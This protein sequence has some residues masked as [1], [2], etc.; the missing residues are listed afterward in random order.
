LTTTWQILHVDDEE[1]QTDLVK[2]YL[3][4]ETTV[5]GEIISVTSQNNFDEAL[6]LLNKQ[7]FDLIILDIR[8]GPID[9]DKEFTEDETGIQ[10]LLQIQQ[11]RFL[12]VIFYTGLPEAV[13]DKKSSFIKVIVK[14]GSSDLPKILAALNEYSNDGFHS[15]PLLEVNR[16]LINHLKNSSKYYLWDC[17]EKNW[18]YFRELKDHTEIVH[19]LCRHLAHSLSENSTQQLIS[20]ITGKEEEKS[21]TIHPCRIYITPPVEE[22]PLAGDIYMESVDGNK[23]Y[24]VLLSPSCDM[25]IRNGNG[26]K[27]ANVLLAQGCLLE[28]QTEYKEWAKIWSNSKKTLFTDLLRNNRKTVG[29]ERYHFLPSAFNLPDQI[30]DFQLLRILKYG[31]LKNLNRIAS[32]DSPFSEELLSRFNRYYGRIGTP[33]I[34]IECI[35]DRLKSIS[36][37]SSETH[38]CSE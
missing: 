20:E 30:I 32:L 34:D 21:D 6:E 10:A 35:C 18:D 4:A 36:E 2:E 26:A 33:D 1:D 16:A 28:D 5:N 27:A 8:V 15:S 13:N 7:H 22:F 9:S 19:L 31:D 12:P 24:Y 11:E 3:N 23:T 25:V 37:Q 17:V 29:S 38:S 14:S